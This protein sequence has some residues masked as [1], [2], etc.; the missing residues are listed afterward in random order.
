MFVLFPFKLRDDVSLKEVA[1]LRNSGGREV[2]NDVEVD[3]NTL[4]KIV[5]EKEGYGQHVYMTP[6]ISK[7]RTL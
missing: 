2:D 5:S 7:Q 3:D 4:Y 1:C 6:V